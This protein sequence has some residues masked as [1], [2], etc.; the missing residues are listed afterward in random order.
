MSHLTVAPLPAPDR[1]QADP[2]APS[3]CLLRHLAR[4][5]AWANEKLLSACVAVRPT[6]ALSSDVGLPFISIQRTLLHLIAAE[7]LWW[8]RLTGKTTD[9]EVLLSHLPPLW[10]GE[11]D[12]PQ[13][14]RVPLR[15]ATASGAVGDAA[16]SAPAEVID[17]S[18]V[19]FDDVAAALRRQC[20]RWVAFTDGLT[21]AAAAAAF[22][23]ADTAGFAVEG[24][25]GRALL[26]V[27]NHGTHHRGQLSVGLRLLLRRGSTAPSVG[28]GAGAGP[29]AA[30]STPS[31]GA[32]APPSLEMDL[33]Y[34]ER[35]APLAAAAAEPA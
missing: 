7:A 10:A 33:S 14:S 13:W 6:D 20:L 21:D 17:P 34:F 19:T 11:P 15:R 16:S 26:H 23:Y 28:V 1:A 31:A 18:E 27:F 8:H 2:V 4:Y 12:G 22:E 29:D 32:G 35:E 9:C 3:A 30:R 5:H 24:R 25:V